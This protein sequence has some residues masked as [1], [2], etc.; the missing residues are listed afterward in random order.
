MTLIAVC[1]T[2]A[3]RAV[4]TVITANFLKEALLVTLQRTVDVQR[5]CQ[6]RIVDAEAKP[7]AI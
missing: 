4:D 6:R 1:G 3:E 2:Q 5:V 7:L